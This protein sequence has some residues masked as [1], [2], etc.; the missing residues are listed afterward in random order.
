MF[1]GGPNQGK[2][3]AYILANPWDL[4]SGVSLEAVSANLKTSST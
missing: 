2:I 1:T 3:R 4:T